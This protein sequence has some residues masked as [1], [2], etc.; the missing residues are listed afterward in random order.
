MRDLFLGKTPANIF[1]N[2]ILLVIATIT[3]IVVFIVSYFYANKFESFE[4]HIESINNFF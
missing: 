2:I 1:S 3:S 4:K